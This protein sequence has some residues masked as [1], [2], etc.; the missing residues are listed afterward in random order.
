MDCLVRRDDNTIAYINKMHNYNPKVRTPRP[1]PVVEKKDKT[2]VMNI[3]E[4]ELKEIIRLY[5]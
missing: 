5:F 3:S 1:R 4:K 2:K